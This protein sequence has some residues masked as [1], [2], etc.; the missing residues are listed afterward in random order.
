MLRRTSVL[1]GGPLSTLLALLRMVRQPLPSGG[2]PGA[3]VAA[4][5]AN[6]PP[7]AGDVPPSLPAAPVP[8]APQP[9]GLGGRLDIT[10]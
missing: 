9:P 4:F 10:A 2:F 1:D 3:A 7:P 5:P 6:A 8:P